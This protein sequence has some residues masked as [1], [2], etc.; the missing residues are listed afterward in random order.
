MI[1]DIEL[2]ERILTGSRNCF[3]CYFKSKAKKGQGK[4]LELKNQ[5]EI[6]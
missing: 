3:K 2:Q 5:K 4:W 6:T 1:W